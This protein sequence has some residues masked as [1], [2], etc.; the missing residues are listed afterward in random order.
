[1]KK[2]KYL[3]LFLVALSVM[4]LFTGCNKG[5]YGEDTKTKSEEIARSL[6]QTLAEGD[7]V[8]AAYDFPYTTKAKEELNAQSLETLW[9]GLS[10]EKGNFIEIVGLEN[11]NW[12]KELRITV[13]CSFEK[14]TAKLVMEFDRTV[15]IKSIYPG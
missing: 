12:D 2:K 1:M 15:K 4:L 10:G 5:K 7:Y 9:K 3:A 11:D 13:D 8:R 6:V 14:G